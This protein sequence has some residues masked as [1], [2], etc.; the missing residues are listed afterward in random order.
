MTAAITSGQRLQLISTQQT[1]ELSYSASEPNAIGTLNILQSNIFGTKQQQ[2]PKEKKPQE[3]FL[4]ELLKKISKEKFLKMQS[5][6]QDWIIELSPIKNP[7]NIHRIFGYLFPLNSGVSGKLCEDKQAMSSLLEREKIPVLKHELFL[8]PKTNDWCPEEGVFKGMFTLFD[9]WGKNV[10][11]KPNDGTGGNQ[12]FHVE[13]ARDLEKAAL[14]IFKTKSML[15]ISP[16]HKI[17]YE[18][19]VVYLDRNEPLDKIQ[20][21]YKKKP[22]CLEKDPTKTVDQAFKEY[23]CS[24]DIKPAEKLLKEIGEKK[25]L[26]IIRDSNKPLNEDYPLH[27]KHNVGKGAKIELL[28]DQKLGSLSSDPNLDAVRE[29]A[30]KAAKCAKVTFASIDIVEA[31][32]EDKKELKIME[33]NS[34][35]MME[36]FSKNEFSDPNNHGLKISGYEIAKRIYTAAVEEMFGSALA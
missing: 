12:V 9:E 18:Y 17:N 19:R 20:L 4:V 29:L 32:N 5:F 36:G 23:I 1:G 6:S 13:K 26:E 2:T 33:V 25:Q 3:R 14:D 30:L 11:V 31:L 28:Y 27:W 34:G 35:I 21:I 16:F 7:Q 15:C 10:V 8:S 22:P 24:L